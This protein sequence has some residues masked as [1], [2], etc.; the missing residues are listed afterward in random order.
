MS[1]AR[2]RIK[3]LL[4]T[5]SSHTH[6]LSF[7]SRKMPAKKS[8][9]SKPVKE[10]QPAAAAAVAQ[11]ETKKT[12]KIV[13]MKEVIPAAMAKLQDMTRWPIVMDPVGK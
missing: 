5:T 11:P 9:P 10:V 12:I 8:T 1:H 3:I 2:A 7:Q 4:S 13:K 6:I